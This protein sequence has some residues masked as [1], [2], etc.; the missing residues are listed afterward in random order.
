ML[1]VG[2]EPIS[3]DING[4]EVGGIAWGEMAQLRLTRLLPFGN[5]GPCR[6]ALTRLI[7]RT[8]F[9]RTVCLSDHTISMHEMAAERIF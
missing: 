5:G 9:K 4:M 1:E 7:R 3:R 6:L 8:V 2:F